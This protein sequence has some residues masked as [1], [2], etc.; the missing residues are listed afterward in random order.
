MTHDL[1]LIIFKL[2]LTVK[3][4]GRLLTYGLLCN[5]PALFC[6]IL[7]WGKA[8]Q[9]HFQ[10]VHKFSNGEGSDLMVEGTQ[11]KKHWSKSAKY[12]LMLHIRHRI[13]TSTR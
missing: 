1:V 2:S 8:L 6:C 3:F 13:Y 7:S 12:I 10:P 5:M 11:F 9:F 4:P